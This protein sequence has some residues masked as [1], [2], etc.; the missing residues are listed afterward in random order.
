MVYDI[1]LLLHP[2]PHL[3]V[4]VHTAL[5]PTRTALIQVGSVHRQDKVRRRGGGMRDAG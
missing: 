2:H 5:Y 4:L 3:T 1:I